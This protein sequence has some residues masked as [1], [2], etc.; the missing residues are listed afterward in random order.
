MNKFSTENLF[1]IEEVAKICGLSRNAMYMHY[2]RQHI[3]P[4]P[5]MC[6]RLYF[7]REEVDRFRALYC[8]FSE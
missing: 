6:H 1:T 2:W 8:P 3:K 5:L 7:K 4:E